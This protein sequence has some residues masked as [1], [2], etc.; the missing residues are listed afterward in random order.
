MPPAAA[1]AVEPTDGEGEGGASARL[2]PPVSL[3]AAADILPAKAACWR[4]RE[5]DMTADV[6]L[7][8]FLSLDL[9]FSL[10]L[11]YQVV[12]ESILGRGGEEGETE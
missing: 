5:L 11:D 12:A 10:G 9:S 1:D 8:L 2:L 6:S 7:F 3:E 4:S